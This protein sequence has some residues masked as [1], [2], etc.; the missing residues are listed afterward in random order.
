[1]SIAIDEAQR[2]GLSR[3]LLLTFRP[4]RRPRRA[5]HLPRGRRK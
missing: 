1:L 2:P 3:N 5:H 4:S